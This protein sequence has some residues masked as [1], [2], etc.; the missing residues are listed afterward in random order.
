[1]RDVRIGA[2]SQSAAEETCNA[3]VIVFEFEFQCYRAVSLCRAWIKW[4][5]SWIRSTRWVPRDSLG[6]W[7]R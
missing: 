6:F 3:I 1:V 2:A 5:S 7:G 4:V